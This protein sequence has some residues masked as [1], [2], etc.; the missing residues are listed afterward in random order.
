VAGVDHLRC[1]GDLVTK[2]AAMAGA[3][4][5]DLSSIRP[6]ESCVAPTALRPLADSVQ[7]DHWDLPLGLALVLGVG[8]PEL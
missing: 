4:S 1:F 7:Y 8:R 3:A 5:F 2:L 6:N